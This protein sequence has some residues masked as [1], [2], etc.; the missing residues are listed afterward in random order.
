ML[1]ETVAHLGPPILFLLVLLQQAGV[2][3]PITP[4]LI[5]AGAASVHGQLSAPAVI[6]IAVGAA[7]LADLGWYTAGYRLGGRALKALC[8]LSL[9]PDSC[10][11]E[12]ERWFGRL[13]TRVLVVAK[14]IPGLG[15]VSTAMAGVVRARL[16]GFLLYD[17]LGNLL[18]ASTA[19]CIGILFRDAVGDVLLALAE[20]GYWGIA[21]IAAAIAGF[22]ALKLLKRRALIRELRQSRISVAELKDLVDRGPAPVIIDALAPAS[23]RR[24][25]MI[26]GAI[27]VETLRLDSDPAR[28]PLDAEVIVYC[29][30]PNEASAAR[31]AQRLIRMGCIRV[32]PLTGGIFAWKDAGLDVEVTPESGLTAAA[33]IRT[34]GQGFSP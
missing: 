30:C 11:S 5:V 4:V 1:Q 15:L 17:V 16:D 24:E 12:T 19:V 8:T 9:S 25:G 26:P 13:G 33:G 34:S 18:W 2:P 28:L 7:L 21:L 6:A 29:A 3:Y 22:I 32:R 14:F 10:V 31:I 23:R 27:P 20:L